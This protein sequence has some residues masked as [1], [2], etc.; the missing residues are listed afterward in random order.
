MKQRNFILL[1]L[2]SILLIIFVLQNAKPVEVNLF[3]WKIASSR[4]LVLFVSIAFGALLS[5][6][7]SLGAYQQQRRTIK[8]QKKDVTKLE[9]EREALKKELEE[10][11]NAALKH[12]QGQQPKQS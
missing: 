8:E 9:N 2:L 10:A 11:K 6:L 5:Y 7:F 3:F 1:L 4:A 12:E